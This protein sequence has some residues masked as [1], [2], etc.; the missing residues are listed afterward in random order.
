MSHPINIHSLFTVIISFSQIPRGDARAHVHKT[1]DRFLLIV[2]ARS[3]EERTT[4]GLKG[5]NEQEASIASRM[6]R[7]LDEGSEMHSLKAV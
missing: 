2:L 5:G 4:C 7:L 1:P 6:K 3:K